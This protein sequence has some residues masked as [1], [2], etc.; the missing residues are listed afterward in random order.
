MVLHDVRNA[1]NIYGDSALINNYVDQLLTTI[2]SSLDDPTQYDYWD[3]VDYLITLARKKG[4]YK[5][6]VPV[7]GS[8]VKSGRTTIKNAHKTNARW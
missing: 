8:N 4:L 7:W 2:G 5:A 1:V 6:L 3:H